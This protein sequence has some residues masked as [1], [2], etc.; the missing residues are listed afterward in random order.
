M[1]ILH[2]CL[3]CFYVDGYSYQENML[4]K[5][6]KKMGYEVEIIASTLSFDEHGNG[7]NIQ[8]G[9]YINEYGIRVTRL[10]YRRGIP[11]RAGKFL[12]IYDGFREAL[13]KS[14]PDIIFIHGCQFCDIRVIARY[15]KKHRVVIYA[16]NHADFSNSATNWASKNI[17]HRG[18]WKT[19]AQRIAPYTEKFYGVLPARVA[20]LTELYGLPKEKCG[21]LVMGADD[22]LAER[23][24]TSG[25]R[26]R[27]RG[28]YG[29]GEHDFLI[30]TGGKIDRWKTQTIL[31]MQAVQRIR[32]PRVRLIVFGSAAPEMT[33]R[34]QELADGDRIRY[35][36][37]IQSEETYNYFAAA[38]LVVFPG[39]HS[40]LWEQAA[41]QGLPMLVRDWEGTRHIDLGGNV[42]FLTRDS[43]EEIREEIERLLADPE[44]YRE[45]QK[46]AEK[47]IREFSYG[48]ISRRAIGR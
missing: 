33:E 29:I 44:A 30:V 35:I 32:N 37:W 25:A 3:A 43:A 12:R 7:C 42:R 5:F 38:D 45:M 46:A 27:I 41:G 24:R 17:L 19:C 2:V 9:A 13:E 31:L 48:A 6:H 47:G 36:G 18:L 26:K 40:V 15:A 16:D 10:P 39:R 14:A 8:P 23:A 22:E 34:V 21:L 20:F 11:D 1:K 28:R 4:P